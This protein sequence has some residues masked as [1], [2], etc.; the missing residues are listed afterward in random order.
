M[1]ELLAAQREQGQVPVPR[2][3][4]DCPVDGCGAFGHAQN[5]HAAYLAGTRH[6]E[7]THDTTEGIDD[8]A[9]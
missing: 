7:D 1:P 3:R 5:S 2:K 8:A 4:W 9:D 6:F